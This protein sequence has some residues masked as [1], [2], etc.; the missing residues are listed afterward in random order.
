MKFSSSFMAGFVAALLVCAI[1]LRIALRKIHVKGYL[2][3]KYDERQKAQQGQS[4]LHTLIFAAALMLLSGALS[5][6]LPY[7]L[8]LFT[9]NIFIIA[10]SSC[11]FVVEQ[12]M[13][14]AYFGVNFTTQKLRFFC[15][16]WLLYAVIAVVWTFRAISD[17]SSFI[18][19]GSFT[20]DG[21]AITVYWY[22]V[23]LY[24]LIL[25]GWFLGKR[26]NKN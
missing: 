4:A 23:L 24:G 21:F 26:K 1:V 3:N 2:N 7:R 6:L 16:I 13:R 17:G 12:L 11:F 25:A 8:T 15:L 9:Q 10:I 22:I 20:P 19:S 5:G 18:Q 14:G